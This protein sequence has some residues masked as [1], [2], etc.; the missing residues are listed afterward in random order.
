MLSSP[1]I[2]ALCASG[3]IFLVASV[4]NVVSANLKDKPD[5]FFA[6]VAFLSLFTF[7]VAVMAFIFFYRPLVLMIDGN[8]KQAVDFFLKTIGF[9]GVITFVVWILLFSGII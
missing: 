9:F 1:Y 4:M 3:Y 7:S 5:T 2:N 6:P 8:K